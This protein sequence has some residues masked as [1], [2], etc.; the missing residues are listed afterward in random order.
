MP[1]YTLNPDPV[2]L[3]G[4]FSAD[5]RPVLTIV[6]GDTI[7]YRLPDAGW[8]AFEQQRPF[9]QAP[10][11]PWRDRQRDPG[12]ALCGPIAIDGARAGMT[13]EIVLD[14]IRPA[15][16]GWVSAGFTH[17]RNPQLG[18]PAEGIERVMCWQLDAQTGTAT[19]QRGQTLTMRPFLGILGMP[20]AEAGQHSTIPP[21]F[22][23]GNI[24]CKE[25]VAGSRLFLPIP[26]D[27]GLFSL[28]DGHAV[29][30]DG[31]VAGPALECPMELVKVMFQLHRDMHLAMPR[32]DTPAGWITFR[33]DQ[34]LAVATKIALNGMLDLMEA[35]YQVDRTDALALA[36]LVVDLRITQI[37]NGICGVH[38]ILPHAA[39]A[40][41]GSSV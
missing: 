23:G 35:M 20:P 5:L 26:V 14:T 3:H 1:T 6:S 27:G 16:W 18:L 38:A 24:D 28:G 10:S 13:L 29:Q 36:S 15:G 39:L 17:P 32:A 4:H 33:F 30:G 37:V 2:S 19:N 31:E 21:R 12:H 34:D 8:H 11:L 22:C 9:A 7:R 25:L 41:S 40:E